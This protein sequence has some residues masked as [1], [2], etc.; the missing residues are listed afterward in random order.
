MIDIDLRDV[1]ED[2]S[3]VEFDRVMLVSD[4]AGE[5]A[6]IGQPWVAGAKV[7]GTI[8]SEVKA[9]K[10]DVIKFKRRKGYRRKQGHRQ[11]F[12]RVRIDEIIS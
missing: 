4:P 2:Q 5:S 12:L 9:D 8:Q 10:I 3:T 6:Q 1:S 11:R 7:R